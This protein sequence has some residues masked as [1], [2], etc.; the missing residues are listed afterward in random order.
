[1]RSKIIYILLFLLVIMACVDI[2]IYLGWWDKK[3]TLS[4]KAMKMDSVLHLAE[5]PKARAASIYP[6]TV[7]PKHLKQVK[8]D[9]TFR[10]PKNSIVRIAQAREKNGWY[11]AAIRDIKDGHLDT[12][13]DIDPTLRNPTVILLAPIDDKGNTS[14]EFELQVSSK[15]IEMGMPIKEKLQ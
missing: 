2:S 15:L 7:T 13:V 14:K 3:E 5:S 4:E 12:Y 8:L 10:E 11:V 1:M 6:L 9:V